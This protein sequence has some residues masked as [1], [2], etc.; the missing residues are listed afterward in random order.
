MVT[1]WAL[2]AKNEKPVRAVTQRIPGLE[3][4]DIQAPGPELVRTRS[5]LENVSTTMILPIGLTKSQRYEAFLHR[6]FSRNLP[7]TEIR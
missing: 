1:A 6:G 4:I 3:H 7:C 5:N 2:S